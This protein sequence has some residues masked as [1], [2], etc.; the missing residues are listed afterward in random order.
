MTR[1]ANTHQSM[2]TYYS[3]S[4]ENAAMCGWTVLGVG[5]T[6]AEAEVEAEE[7]LPRGNDMRADTWRKNLCTMS[8]SAAIRRGFVPRGATLVF[9]EEDGPLGGFHFEF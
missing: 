1:K 6:A 3:M 4:T 7:R 9:E 2:S 8:K 5:S